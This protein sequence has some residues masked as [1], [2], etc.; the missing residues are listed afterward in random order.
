MRLLE[1]LPE[2]VVTLDGRRLPAADVAPIAV[3]R[4]RLVL[5]TPAQCLITWHLGDPA[6]A[7][8]LGPAPGDALRV[9]VGGRREPLFVG[10]V[11]VVEHAHGADASLELRLRA[12]DALHRLRMR[13]HTRKHENVDLVGLARVL[14]EGAGLDVVGGGG[15]LGTVY[16]CA[17]TDLDLLV[18]AAGR[19]GLHPV[20]DG[21]A[22]RLVDLAGEGDP[23]E[24]VL[25]EGLHSAE[26]EVSQ[27]PSFRSAETVRWDPASAAGG[28][29]TAR[30][31]R[32][33]AA[34]R[35]DPA[36]E[37]AG[38]GGT[39]RRADEVMADGGLAA[40]LAQADLD[41]RR[42]GE[43]TADLVADGDPGLRAGRRV[44][45]VGVAEGFEGTYGVCEA[46]HTI[47]GTG[48]T[49]A[50][51]TRPPAGPGPRNPDRVTL[52]VVDRV[53][54]PEGRGR[55]T[56]R[57]VAY[58]DL[59]TEWAPVLL[60]AAGEGKGLI[61]LPDGGDTVLVLLPGGDPAHAV[62]LGALLGTVR[63]HDAG[64][65]G[66]RG[67]RYAVRTRDGQRVLLDGHART[68]TLTDGHGSVV[69]LGPDLV[70]L[71]AATDLL[72]E[73][74]GR[75]VTLRAKTVDFEEAP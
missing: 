38:G 69:E 60:A 47:D 17:R 53:D 29:S 61:A 41:V 65:A 66:P 4:V 8:R 46:V 31:E 63:T 15:H 22:L 36:P 25:G 54:D 10:E 55:V 45:L 19:A 75:G 20:V 21:G 6:A 16:Q 32:A 33:R 34:V 64:A 18:E 27:E 73:A 68:L 71:T 56:V 44:R 28:T 14:A 37:A 1:G 58:P 5:G 48:Y 51:S 59:V 9:E 40:A 26:L 23:V 30:S 49:T 7:R 57:L 62:V 24:L 13:Q 2:L 11:T 43:V 39:L 35:A 50:V 52:G 74:P 3:V 12:Y 70:R 42:A 72:I 67:A